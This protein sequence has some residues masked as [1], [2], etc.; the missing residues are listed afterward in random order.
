[1]KI[2]QA[3]KWSFGFLSLVAPGGTTQAKTINQVPFVS[4]QWTVPKVT[5][6]YTT[7]S[8]SIRR[9]LFYSIGGA[10]SFVYEDPKRGQMNVLVFVDPG[11]NRVLFAVEGEVVKA[12]GSYGSGQDQF[13]VPGNLDVAPVGNVFV[14]DTGNNRI[15]GYSFSGREYDIQGK[16][17][18]DDALVQQF[19][20]NGGNDFSQPVQVCWEDGGTSQFSDDYLWVLDRWK[21][22][23]AG[24]HIGYDGE[25]FTAS[26]YIYL[27]LRSCGLCRV[28][29]DPRSITKGRA[30]GSPDESGSYCTN[31][32][33]IYDAANDQFLIYTIQRDQGFITLG[34]QPFMVS[35]RT[36]PNPLPGA[37]YTFMSADAWGNICA[38]DDVGSR[39]CKLDS[40]LNLLDTYGSGGSGP[41]GS[42]E[43]LNPVC[44]SFQ[45]I[46][47]YGTPVQYTTNRCML[48]EQWG[49]ATGIQNLTM[50]VTAKDALAQ[51]RSAVDS[52]DVSYFTT[53]HARATV[54]ILSS[55][56]SLI[57]TLVG[58]AVQVPGPHMIVW[59]GRNDAGMAVARCATYSARIRT[60]SLYASPETSV[61]TGS[62][63]YKPRIARS[64]IV[65]SNIPGTRLTFDGRDT[66]LVGNTYAAACSV[67]T[68]HTL[69]VPPTQAINGTYYCFDRWSNSGYRTQSVLFSGD[70]TIALNLVTS[71]RGPT[72]VAADSV[73][74]DDAFDCKSPYLFSGSA[75]LTTSS[76][77]D[78]FRTWGNVK[79]RFPRA[80]TNNDPRAVLSISRPFIARGAR[81]ETV[82]ST[83]TSQSNLWGGLRVNRDGSVFLYGDTLRNADIGVADSANSAPFPKVDIQGCSF[84]SNRSFDVSVWL[85]PNRSPS[86][87]IIGNSFRAWQA[88]QLAV[89]SPG[90]TATIQN[91]FFYNAPASGALGPSALNLK[92]GWQG[93]ISGNIFT[94]GQSNSLG[95]ALDQYGGA[96][97]VEIHNNRFSIITGV[98]SYALRTAT[99]PAPSVNATYN[100]WNLNDL[101]AIASVVWDKWD[102]ATRCEAIYSPWLTPIGG[103]GGGGGCP[104]V[105][106]GSGEGF[107]TDN[108]I[109]GESDRRQDATSMVEDTYPLDEA[110]AMVDGRV[111]LRI[112]EW[113]QEVT[114]LDRVGLVAVPPSG[115]FKVATSVDGRILQYQSDPARLQSSQSGTAGT[116]AAA[117]SSFYGR[118]GDSLDFRVTYA[119]RADPTTIRGLGV[120]FRP[121]PH[122]IAGPTA[123][124]GITLRVS[125][126]PEGERWTTLASLVPRE[127]WSTVIV[128]FEETIPSPQRIRFVWHSAHSLGWIGIVEERPVMDLVQLRCVEAR[129]SSGRSVRSELASVDG[130][131]ATLRPGEHIDFSFDA[132]TVPAGSIF[133]LQARGR[134]EHGSLA[135]ASRALPT[136][137][138]FRRIGPNPFN[139]ETAFEL[140]VPREGRATIRVFDTAGRLVRVVLDESLVPGAYT[141]RW[142][143]TDQRGGRV[144]SGI[145]FLD[146]K[147]G[148]FKS[149]ERLVLIR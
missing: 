98:G 72:T 21:G 9:N 1:M 20:I 109:L 40:G 111:S 96:P 117:S 11:W 48:V 49:D 86:A 12:L 143:G 100:D 84:E 27:D 85:D 71:G 127:N 115:G 138:A 38:I 39:L 34:M 59:D 91:N 145:Y 66:T 125:P 147:A 106:V 82:D 137:Y 99:L 149:R 132:S 68:T 33:Y 41:L 104:Y 88:V 15:V 123:P 13:V 129:H 108:T 37:S 8:D 110:R 4:G 124:A 77:V 57:R 92:G 130:S 121:K 131:I 62:F 58:S 83:A 141:V 55:G 90:A 63:Y 64:F 142:D 29:A 102:D 10:G 61:V 32:L 35:V 54:E 105:L 118:A 112:A 113:E 26:P 135:L 7:H 3:V 19:V 122:V 46:K 89:T 74:Y 65:T 28:P 45:K 134:Y 60:A 47:H 17:I 51:V 78:T 148:E 103:G 67:C 44:L 146:L 93:L 95:I 16:M 97:S 36:A 69:G 50:G 114:R 43:M 56:G 73:L 139:A 2:V 53:D 14:A 24:Y 80:R 5:R 75:T 144:A 133:A 87:S 25:R 120:S 30:Y 22:K 76:L 101:T 81:F 136:S 128:P 94:L 18:H 119:D 6:W 126:D 79:F 52:V 31:D 116:S 70:S 140:R 23:I 42:E 107:K